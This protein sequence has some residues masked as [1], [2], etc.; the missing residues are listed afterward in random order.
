[1]RGG[2]APK[3]SREG[4]LRPPHSN[5]DFRSLPLDSHPPCFKGL[6]S[7]WEIQDVLS[8]GLSKTKKIQYSKRWGDDLVILRRLAPETIDLLLVFKA[9]CGGAP[10]LRFSTKFAEFL[11]IDRILWNLVKFCE[12]HLMQEGCT[13][14]KPGKSYFH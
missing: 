3:V 13:I 5:L 14:G 2:E 9:F 1:M 12:C 4:R 6:Y 10:I 11:R 8:Y 7:H